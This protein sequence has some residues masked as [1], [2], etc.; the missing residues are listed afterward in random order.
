MALYWLEQAEASYR[1]PCP[2][3]MI[4]NHATKLVEADEHAK[5][6]QLCRL[7]DPPLRCLQAAFS[8]VVGIDR[9]RPLHWQRDHLAT[10]PAAQSLRPRL[11]RASQAGP[12]GG[13]RRRLFQ[14][15]SITVAN[16]NFP[17]DPG[18]DAP[19]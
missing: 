6:N 18:H 10:L 1:A 12:R 3:T 8:D 19:P 7:L 17:S 2:P 14:H 5:Y 13:R 11:R 15:T 4:I 9:P 16:G